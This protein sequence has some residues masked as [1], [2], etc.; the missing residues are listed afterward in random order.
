MSAYSELEYRA[1]KFAQHK[2]KGQLR[3]HGSGASPLPPYITHP[4]AVA[5]IV[6]SVGGT[7]EMLAA[8]WLHDV[9]EDC[10]VT[11]TTIAEHFGPLVAQYVRDLTDVARAGD[12]SGNRATRVTLNI[13]HSAASCAES[14]TVK[15]ADLIHNT[16]RIWEYA[17]K[18][19]P[20]FWEE[21]RRLADALTKADVWLHGFHSRM[22]GHGGDDMRHE[23]AS[24]STLFLLID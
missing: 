2:H 8:A 7:A 21:T 1:A 15:M 18:F 5:D 13:A 12:G 23:Y 4:A 9:V 17:P 3:K 10:G 22:G 19:A 11:D 14:Q 20:V 16:Y 6:R 24:Y